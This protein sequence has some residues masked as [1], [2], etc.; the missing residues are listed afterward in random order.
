MCVG[1]AAG[2]KEVQLGRGFSGASGKELDALLFQAGLY[3]S[4]T[5][6]DVWTSNIVRGRPKVGRKNRAPKSSEISACLPYLLSEIELINPRIIVC[7][8]ATAVHALMNPSGQSIHMRKF[9]GTVMNIA[10][11]QLL[12]T[13]HP[14]FVMRSK[15]MGNFQPQASVISDLKIVK[16]VAEEQRWFLRKDGELISPWK[17]STYMGSCSEEHATILRNCG[18]VEEPLKVGYEMLLDNQT[19]N[20]AVLRNSTIGCTYVRR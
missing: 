9:R 2:E 8:G 15:R 6:S 20:C 16:R 7:L 5:S 18:F 13:Y 3:R 11:R 19:I 17:S 4:I 14:S 12:G 10:G 1:E